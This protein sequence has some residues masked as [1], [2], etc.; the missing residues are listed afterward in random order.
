MD[1]PATL[2]RKSA[3]RKRFKD[4][5]IGDAFECNGNLGLRKVL[6]L[7]VAYGPRTCPRGHTLAGT[8]WLTFDTLD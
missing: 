5:K 6:E 7:H 4:V 2:H 3:T 8:N 1:T